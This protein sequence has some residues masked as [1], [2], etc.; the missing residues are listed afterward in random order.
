MPKLVLSS[1]CC[2]AGFTV[3]SIITTEDKAQ[4]SMSYTRSRIHA[5]VFT[6]GEW[7]ERAKNSNIEIYKLEGALIFSDRYQVGA[8]VPFQKN[9]QSGNLGGDSQG[10]GD[11]SLQLG[12]EYLPDWDYNPYRP[13]GIG[14]L[15]LILPT[16][17]SIYESREGNGFDSRGRGFWGVGVGTVLIKKWG[18]WDLNTNFEVHHSFAKKVN[19]PPIEGKV[20]PG[21]GGS[22]ALGGGLNWKNIRLGGLINWVYEEAIDVEGKVNSEGAPRRYASGSVLLSY[23]FPDNQSVVISYSDETI[24]GS[25]FNTSLSKS[26]TAFYQKRWER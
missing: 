26:I 21:V 1:P 3:P 25:P 17:K 18:M 24:F 9:H 11:I 8:S 22:A 13:K 5:D 14:Y 6:S 23:M 2:G 7:R 20:K 4:L 16:G 12:Y 15:S 10:L 19:H